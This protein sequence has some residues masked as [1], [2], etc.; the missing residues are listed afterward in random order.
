MG[1]GTSRHATRAPR[2]SDTPGSR[3]PAETFEVTGG[4]TAHTLDRHPRRIFG[5]ACLEQ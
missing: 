2:T 3:S 1:H 5:N 4:V